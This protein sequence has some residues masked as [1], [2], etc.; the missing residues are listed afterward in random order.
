MASLLDGWGRVEQR[1]VSAYNESSKRFLGSSLAVV[2][3]EREPIKVLKILME[4]LA[5]EDK[6]GLW[7][8]NF[9]GVP[10]A[11]SHSPFDLA[12]LDEDNRIIQAVEITQTSRF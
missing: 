10:I 11:R 12:F 9:R 5:P 7:L 4:G 2:D 8:I 3:S 6:A 1:F